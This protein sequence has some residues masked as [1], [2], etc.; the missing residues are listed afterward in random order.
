LLNF[1]KPLTLGQN[2]FKDPRDLGLIYF[3]AMIMGTN[4]ALYKQTATGFKKN[5][6]QNPVVLFLW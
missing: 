1:L 2:D 3:Y 4:I 6:V 5:P